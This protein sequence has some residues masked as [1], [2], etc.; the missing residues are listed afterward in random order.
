MDYDNDPLNTTTLSDKYEKILRSQ[1][2]DEN[3]PGTILHDFEILLDFI[4]AT[5]IEVSNKNN[6]LSNESL[7]S[8]NSKLSH[9]LDIRHKRPRQRSYPNINGLYL[10]LRATGFV[11]PERRGKKLLMI[12]DNTL[13]QSWEKCNLAERYFILFESWLIRGSPE[14]VGESESFYQLNMIKWLNFFREIPDRGL[15]ISGNTKQE[16]RINYSPGLYSV[17]LLD[18]F[19]I[20]SVCRCLP[21]E[22]KGWC[23]AS[24]HRTPF[25]DALLQLMALYYRKSSSYFCLDAEKIEESFGRLQ[26]VIQPFFPEWHKNLVI[27][28]PEFHDGIHVFKVSLGTVWRR[29]A[30]PGKSCFEALSFSILDAFGF[31]YDHLYCFLVKNRY[32]FKREIKH[33]TMDEPPYANEVRIGDL[34]ALPGMTMV[35]WYDFGDNW[36]FNLKLECIEPLKSEIKGPFVLEEHGQPPDQYLDF[37]Y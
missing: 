18:L 6:F 12:L 30:I 26:P 16:Q 5:C 31:D 34:S 37:S 28:K 32:G 14:I 19:G 27:R 13:L 23:V 20:I 1:V 29:I 9:P 17:A 22:G 33:P 36:K 11:Y 21:N 24:V 3:Y 25:G 8:L 10:L 7:A 2:I 4:D 15:K 35:F